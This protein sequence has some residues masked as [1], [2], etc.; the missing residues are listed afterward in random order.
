PRA[1]APAPTAAPAPPRPA[2]WTG[3]TARMVRRWVWF[4][5]FDTYGSQPRDAALARM[6]VSPPDPVR[7]G[8]LRRECHG[9][10][11]R[12]TPPRLGGRR[13][14]RQDDLKVLGRP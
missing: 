10:S 13:R 3:V 8:A 1:S 5:V 9:S 7:D 12:G 2:R 11:R 6:D 4:A 14:D